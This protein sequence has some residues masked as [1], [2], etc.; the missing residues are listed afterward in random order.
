M[1]GPF[2]VFIAVLVFFDHCK[3]WMSVKI[4]VIY[5]GSADLGARAYAMEKLVGIDLPTNL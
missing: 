4:T 5:D 2:Q 1:K 3:Q